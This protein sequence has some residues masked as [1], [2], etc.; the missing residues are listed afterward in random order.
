MIPLTPRQRAI[1]DHLRAEI[2]RGPCPTLRE[3]GA[4]FGIT[5]TNGVL[6]H[7]NTLERKGYLLRERGQARAIRLVPEPVE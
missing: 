5:T 1:L 3:I 4:R 6:C 7:L 2:A